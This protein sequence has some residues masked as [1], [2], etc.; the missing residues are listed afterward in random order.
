[1]TL[2]GAAAHKA[3]PG[4]LVI[5]CSY[6][7]YKEEEARDHEPKLVYVDGCNKIQRKAVAVA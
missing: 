6:A 5:I 1:M 2:N 7:D 4:D 3:G